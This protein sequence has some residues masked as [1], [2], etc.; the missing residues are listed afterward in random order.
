MPCRGRA[1]GGK[2]GRKAY[3]KTTPRIRL[4]RV[5]PAMRTRR[6]FALTPFKKWGTYLRNADK[7]PDKIMID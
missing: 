4:R 3:E 1:L 6:G 7:S 2:G 5:A